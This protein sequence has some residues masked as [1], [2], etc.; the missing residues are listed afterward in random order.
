MTSSLLNL[1]ITAV[2]VLLYWSDSDTLSLLPHHFHYYYY[3]YTTPS[4]FILQF[5]L[6]L[7]LNIFHL[8]FLLTK[9]RNLK[10]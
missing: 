8:F 7:A 2:Y 3:S 5:F 4:H 9:E 10:Y 1:K 6:L